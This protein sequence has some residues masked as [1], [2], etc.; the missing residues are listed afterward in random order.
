MGKFKELH[1]I[2]MDMFETFGNETEKW[3]EDAIQHLE[4]RIIE[5]LQEST[6]IIIKNIIEYVFKWPEISNR[7]IE[8]KR[9]KFYDSEN[10]I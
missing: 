8:K 9:S 6:P 10:E 1:S 3:S 2:R 4:A 7:Y 5:V